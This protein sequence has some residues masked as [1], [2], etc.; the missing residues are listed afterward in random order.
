MVGA[1]FTQ[2]ALSQ[3][4]AVQS[5]APLSVPAA[6]G[7]PAS[8]NLVTVLITAA[9]TILGIIL[10][11]WIFKIFD[12]RRADKREELA[13]YER[14]SKPLAASAVSLLF[15]LNEIVL[16]AHRPVYLKGSGIPAGNG[17]GSSFRAYKKMSTLYRLASLLG[18][19]RACRREF[20]YLRLASLK[21]NEP[22]DR[23]ITVFENALA[24]GSWVERERVKRLCTFWNIYT[25]EHLE[26]APKLLE[27]IGVQIDNLIYDKLEAAQAED[28]IDLNESQRVDLCLS[29]ASVLTCSLTTNEINSTF[30]Q[31]TW[32]EAFNIIAT[33]EAWIYKDWQSAIGDIML[34]RLEEEDRKFEVLGYGEFERMCRVG[35]QQQK[36]WIRCLSDIFDGVSFS[37]EDRF[38]ARPR[39]LRALARATPQLVTA[40]HASQGPRSIVSDAAIRTADSILREVR[41]DVSLR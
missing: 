25:A 4:G 35:D 34:T 15:R 41:E 13:V 32:A 12:Q 31:Q 16:Q 11:D 14:Y 1:Y 9:V 8:F 36:Q 28:L 23:A 2:V 24:D 18:W 37:I 5:R 21:E 30:L 33:R 19:V 29:V 7:E 27:N 6:N 10:K 40:L 22:I 26:R 20:S 38:D 3:T 39:Q 17:Q